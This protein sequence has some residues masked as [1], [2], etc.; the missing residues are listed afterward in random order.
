MRQHTYSEDLHCSSA[1][2]PSFPPV[3]LV[4]FLALSFLLI[5]SSAVRPATVSVAQR[6]PAR[7]GPALVCVVSRSDAST[8]AAPQNNMDAVVL[9]ENGRLRQPYPEYNEAGRARFASE[10][11]RTGKKYRVTFGGGEVGSATVKG[12]DTGCNNIH[13]TATVEDKGRIPAHLS[14]LAT[15]SSSLGTKQSARRAPSDVERQA[16]MKLVSKIYRSRGTTLSM[17]RTLKTTN[18]TATDL[19]G[20]GKFELI[21]SFVIETKTARTPT[22]PLGVGARRDLFLI[23]E[24]VGETLGQPGSLPA[25]SYK[26]ALINFQSY[27]LPP[28]GFDSAVDFVDQLDLDG[29]GV[30]EVFVTQ[31][32][33]DAYGYSIYKKTNGHWRSVY[34]TTG[35]AC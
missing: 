14:A 3:F 15:N 7:G 30:A 11:F 8:E 6:S 29:D 18:L 35:D 17:L 24:P 4:F 16:V 26:P 20:D 19:D 25:L 34:T 12:F 33:F 10:Y 28:E 32:G 1:A 13:A 31:H 22:T 27:K 2:G 21:G 5:G 23:A 9:V